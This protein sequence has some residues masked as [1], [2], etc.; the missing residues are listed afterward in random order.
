MDRTCFAVSSIAWKGS[1]QGGEWMKAEVGVA[2]D[3]A[4]VEWSA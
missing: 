1:F 4:K 3:L 2:E